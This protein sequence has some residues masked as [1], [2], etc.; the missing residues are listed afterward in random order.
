MKEKTNQLLEELIAQ[1][2]GK[3]DFNELRDQLFKR[4]VEALLKSELTAHL[5]HPKG[6]KPV[7][8]NPRNGYSEMS[9]QRPENQSHRNFFHKTP[10]VVTV[11]RFSV[12][13]PV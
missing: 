2:E 13:K 1:L 11:P 8:D 6:E 7:S 3:E 9:V 4:G 5:G 12:P 10:V